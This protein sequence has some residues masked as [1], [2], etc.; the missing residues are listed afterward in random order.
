MISSFRHV[1]NAVC[2]LLGNS[3]ASE[4]RRL[5]ITQKKIYNMYMSNLI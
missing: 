4:F 2:L 1:L 3:R 5:G